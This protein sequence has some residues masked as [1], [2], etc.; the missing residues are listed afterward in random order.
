MSVQEKLKACGF[1]DYESR[2]WLQLLSRNPSTAYEAAKGA[3]IPNSKAYEVLSKLEARGFVLASQNE[4]RR[5]YSPIR[6]GDFV[7]HMRQQF[8]STLDSLESELEALDTAELAQPLWGLDKRDR[9]ED[10]AGRII[11]Q[12]KSRVLIHVWREDCAIV[13]TALASK[14]GTGLAAASVLFGDEGELPGLTYLHPLSSTILR[15]KGSRSLMVC[16]DGNTA[17]IATIQGHSATGVWSSNP[18]F[19][20]LV[21]DFIRHD[22]YILKIVNRF[23]P[24]LRAAFGDE[25]ELLRDVFSDKEKK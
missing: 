8:E 21:E 6:A 2:I 4:G 14:V 22:I 5:I 9:V 7:S 25:Y 20:D 17:L 18:G 15:E 19:A 23:G 10:R 11:R 3:G 1:S 16:A 24:E 12:A 13:E